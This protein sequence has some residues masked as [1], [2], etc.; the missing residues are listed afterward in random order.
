MEHINL[1][2][3][4]NVIL[5]FSKNVKF[6]G[7]TKLYKL[8]YYLDFTHFKETGKSVTGYNYFAWDF[9]PVPKTLYEEL[10]CVEE[11]LPE[12]FKKKINIT[13]LDKFHEIRAKAPINIA[14]FSKREIRILKELSD[15]FKYDRAKDMKEISHLKGDPWDRTIEEKGE[16]QKI[17]YFLSLDDSSE[18]ISKEEAVEKQERLQET[19][20]LING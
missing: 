10:D 3:T 16:Y 9:G 2:K 7:K 6:L 8:L 15:I 18:S 17:D 20:K 4:I 5:Y 11:N 12:E 13:K 19:Y 1:D 14:V